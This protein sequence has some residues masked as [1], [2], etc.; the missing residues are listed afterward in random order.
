[1]NILLAHNY[2][3]QPGG[4]DGVFAD[5]GALLESRGHRV[6]RFT[7]HNATINGRSRAGVMRDTLWNRSA[8]RAIGEVVHRSGA[9][10]VHFHNTF[11]LISPAAYHAA[12]GA[13]AGAAV[14]QTLHNY[15][16]L[17]PNSLFLR[18]G[19]SCEACLGRLP[20]PAI[21]HACYRASRVQSAAVVAMIATHRTLGT[22]TK[23]VD[24]FICL[25]EFSRDKFVEGGLP[26]ERLHIK[27]N[28]VHPAP[29]VALRCGSYAVF[30]G[31]LGPEKG[32][33]VLVDA[34][35][36]LPGNIG[37]KIIGSGPLDDYVRRA[38][39]DDPRIVLLG[40][41]PTETVY[42]VIG[43]AACLVAPSLCYENQPRVVI[44]ALAKG[45]PVIVPRLGALTELVD[46]G[47]TG[48]LFEPGNANDLARRIR[49]LLAESPARYQAMRRAA[50]L[51]YEANYTAETNYDVLMAVY[52]Q[53]LSR[54]WKTTPHQPLEE[55]TT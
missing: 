23:A 4:E 8:A 39:R 21:V 6:E 3:Q 24:A 48:L 49:E 50:R 53:A 34:W 42:Q 30:V 9:T 14:V 22:W 45:T 55:C 1:M 41:Q 7:M 13:G 47:C 51:E 25:S 33:H 35:S 15:R 19:K 27:A 43:A 54:R 17:C 2:Y 10:V 38:A 37:L 29:A 31:R 5:E 26:A 44:E 28:F 32:L 46:H 18:N 20:W 16:L 52:E 40:R 11:P 36:R 12:R